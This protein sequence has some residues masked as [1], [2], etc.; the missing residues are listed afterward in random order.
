MK[1]PVYK[2]QHTKLII[3]LG[4]VSVFSMMLLIAI[5]S[6][7]S[8]DE[9]NTNMA[10]MIESTDHKTN[11]AYQM[12]DVIRLRSGAVRSLLQ[13]KE[14]EER[15]RIFS[16]LIQYT[17]TYNES[18]VEL[19]S[20]GANER[21]QEILDSIAAADDL[22]KEAYD[23]TG[24]IIYSMV[25]QP[26]ELRSRLG[27]VQLREL[28][29]LNHL[30]EL[31]KLEKQLSEEA[32]EESRT[33]YKETQRVLA[34][35]VAAAFALSLIISILVISR[36]SKANK[37]IAH[38]ATFDDLTGLHNRRSFEE[39]LAHVIAL[40]GRNASDSYGMLYLDLDRFKIV[41]DTCG[42]HAGDL[43]LQ[44]IT[45]LIGSRLRKGDL[46]ARLGGD[47]FAII[48]HATNFNHV[49][50]LAEDLRQ[51][52]QDF[53]FHYDEHIFKVS[54]CIGVVPIT[55]DQT[56]IEVL[57]QDVDSACY[58]AKQ[59][60][61]NRVHVVSEGDSE[62]VKYRNDIAGIQ[63]IRK[64]L[65]E[66]Q[67][68]LYFQ[69]VYKILPN[70]VS[71]EHCEI[72]LRIRSDNG[73]LYSPAEFIPVAEKYNLMSEIDSW[74]FS[75]VIDWIVENQNAYELPRL[76]IN[77][78]GLSFIDEEFKQFVVERL[79]RGDV[80]PEMVAFEITE[81]AAVD[82]MGKAREFIDQIQALGARFALDDFGSGFSTFAYLKQ[83]P[84]DYLKIDGSLV[85]NLPTDSVDREMVQA[86]NKIGHTVGAKT[87]A[88][89]VEN[90]ETLDILR[91]MGV[92]Y[93]QG[94]GLCKPTPLQELTNMLEEDRDNYRKAS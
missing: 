51:R 59:S 35:V 20:A 81:T 34:M 84:L 25:S 18:R 27:E 28:V 50:Q 31:V 24:Q 16:K 30:N 1:A 82:N 29:L 32:L 85:K 65:E 41:N 5:V 2:T 83:L 58:V 70:G 78:S 13:I 12:R 49:V 17:A 92:D 90:D 46:F 14:A 26:D 45:K 66:D 3:G 36:V 44:D 53:T 8:M 63:H 40:V 7:T 72:L 68:T 75:H 80:S 37:R 74:V 52:V 79:T 43:L 23:K 71:L 76:L 55:G 94:F 15:E 64:A 89:F 47:E 62:V 9:V 6:M 38:L 42:H 88:E 4:F 87:I 60:G 69:P 77:L 57:L 91:N 61:R 19:V 67:L 33:K 21:E 11:R 56:N 93:A 54:L 39:N 48:A 22:A 73:E 86:I 10:Q